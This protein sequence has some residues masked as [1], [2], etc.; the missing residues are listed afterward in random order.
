MNNF[1]RALSQLAHMQASLE[2]LHERY[3]QDAEVDLKVGSEYLERLGAVAQDVRD[4]GGH[5]PTFIRQEFGIY[6]HSVDTAYYRCVYELKYLAKDDRSPEYW[7]WYSLLNELTQ[8][9]EQYTIWRSHLIED[10][11]EQRKET[12]S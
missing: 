1:I 8:L 12:I 9:R 3:F 6:N 2:R 11:M 4:H 10:E 7:A 5:F